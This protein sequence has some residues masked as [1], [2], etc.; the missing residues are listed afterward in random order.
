LLGRTRIF[1]ALSLALA[2]SACSSGVVR[3]QVSRVHD[4]PAVAHG[5]TF[6]IL[7]RKDAPDDA[8]YAALIAAQLEAH[9]YRRAA[10]PDTATYAVSFSY[11]IDGGRAVSRDLPLYVER[12]GET[13]PLDAATGSGTPHAAVTAGVGSTQPAFGELD[14]APAALRFTRALVVSIKDIRSDRADGGNEVFTARARSVGSSRDLAL[15]MPAM[16]EAV[17]KDFPGISGD[18]STAV[19]R[20]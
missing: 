13:V 2:I 20:P 11:G 19:G 7:P 1:P 16:I 5:E 6:V 3:T 17:F 12:E 15:V 8:R 18:T 9:G 10:E 4:M 14:S